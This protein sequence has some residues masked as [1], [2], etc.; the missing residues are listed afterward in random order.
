MTAAPLANRWTKQSLYAH[1]DWSPQ[2]AAWHE[3]QLY[4]TDWGFP[5]GDIQQPVF[6][7]YGDADPNVAPEWG[8]YLANQIPDARLTV[9]PGEGHISGLVHHAD[10]ILSSSR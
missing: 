1:N 2:Q 5:L 3:A 8:T 4:Y 9:L 10:A 6:L 7:F